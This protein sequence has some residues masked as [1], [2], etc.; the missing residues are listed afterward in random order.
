MRLKTGVT[1]AEGAVTDHRVRFG[2]DTILGAVQPEHRVHRLQHCGGGPEGDVQRHRVPVALGGLGAG[3]EM[4]AHPGEFG[5]VGALEAEDRL[6]LVAHGEDG[7]RRLAAV[8]RAESGEELLGDGADDL[9]LLRIGVLRLVDQDVVQP[10][11]Q[12]EQHPGHGG[13][14]VLAAQQR[15]GRQD[16]VVVIEQRLGLLLRLIGAQKRLGQRQQGGGGGGDSGRAN[17]FHQRNEPLRLTLQRRQGGG[18]GCRRL[19]GDEGLAGTALR[20]QEM[21]GV[22][23]EGAHAV[24]RGVEPALDADSALLIGLAAGGQRPAGVAQPRPVEGVV[25][26]GLAQDGRLGDARRH[27]QRLVNRVHRAVQTMEALEQALDSPALAGQLGQDAG[28]LLGVQLGGQAGHR[29]AKRAVGGGASGVQHLVPRLGQQAGGG[30]LVHH[31]EMRGES[32]LQREAAQQRLAEGVDGLDLHAARAIHHLGEQ[33]AG[34]GAGLGARPLAAEVGEPVLQPFVG[35]SRPDAQRAVDAD[36]HLRRRRLGE[37]QA[38]DARRRGAGQHQPQHAVGQ[39]LRL[40]GPGGGAH[41]HRRQRVGG[42]PLRDVGVQRQVADGEVEDGH[43]PMLDCRG[44]AK[45]EPNVDPCAGLAHPVQAGGANR[46]RDRL[47]RL[48][49]GM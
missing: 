11:V 34:D 20:R 41:P 49:D 25:G 5:G 24:F 31:L 12:L 18:E 21:A 45:Q 43:A 27:A 38:E 30:A 1:P 23:L 22:D 37:G 39:H 7:A 14:A 8:P 26:A 29:L 2:R 42:E 28:E 40:A 17:P 47:K 32:G 35:Q 6:L 48:G 36:G 13:H 19:L 3:L 46:H 44:T 15:V 4:A 10:A 16:Q 9:P 33:P